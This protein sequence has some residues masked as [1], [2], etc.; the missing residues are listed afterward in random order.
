MAYK[1]KRSVKAGMTL[2][3]IRFWHRRKLAVIR[4]GAVWQG[5]SE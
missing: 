2:C 5:G 1:I 4:D 3:S